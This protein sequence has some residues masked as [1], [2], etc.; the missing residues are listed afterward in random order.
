MRS[1]SGFTLVESLVATALMLTVSGAVFALMTPALSGSHAQPEAADMQQRA[2]VAADVIQRDLRMVGAGL[3]AGPQTGPLGRYFAPVVPR[4]IGR[5]LADPFAVVRSDAI[6]ITYSAS[7]WQT[8]TLDPM[9]PAAPSLRVDAR[10]N[11]PAGRPVCGYAAGTDLLVFDRAGA[12]DH[13]TVSS[14]TGDQ[15]LL[16]AHRQDATSAYAPGAFVTP[17]ETHVYWFDAANRQLRHYDGDQSDVPV[18]DNVVNVR[19]EYFG[20]PAPPAQPKPPTGVA[21][22][23][24]DATGAPQPLPTLAADG[25]SLAP[26]PL[27]MLADGPWCGDGANRYD[28]DVLRVRKVR[29]TLRVQAAQ[30]AFRAIGP[31]FAVPGTARNARTA[32]PDLT[33]QFDVAPRNLTGGR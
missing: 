19:F 5:Q 1:D 27:S 3:G 15:A 4:R 17:A 8:T 9:L 26:L 20:E 33:V 32:L 10:P 2:R 13:F 14:V 21:N 31:A 24:Y 29:V 12:F 6:S 28:A 7:L 22:C 18:V 11:C 16:R 30:A 23:L 25:G